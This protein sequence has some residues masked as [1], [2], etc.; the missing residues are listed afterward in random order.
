M[1]VDYF[2][3]IDG[4]P[5]DS[6]DA[7]HA[8]EIE[9][10]TVSWGESAVAGPAA[11]RGGAAGKAHIGDLVFSAATSKASPPLMLSCASGEHLKS[12]VLT[13]RTAGAAPIDF[14]VVRL[15]EVLVTSYA[16]EGTAGIAPVD[17]VSVGFG[18][19]ELEFRPQKDD[20]SPEAPIVAAWDVAQGRKL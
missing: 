8:G 13:C 2:L 18:R 3:A 20:G 1:A 15:G 14:L 6:R 17:R 5:G 7:E 16:V 12:A 11:G 4:I 9:L 10:Q 19:I